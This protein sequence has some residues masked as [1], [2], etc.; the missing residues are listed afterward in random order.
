MQAVSSAARVGTSQ[1]NVMGGISSVEALGWV[2]QAAV[3]NRLA[4]LGRYSGRCHTR[5]ATGRSSSVGPPINESKE[6]ISVPVHEEQVRAEKRTVVYEEVGVDKRAVQETER[7]SDT[8]RREELVVD[9]EGRVE[10]D[11][12]RPSQSRPA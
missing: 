5:A 7:V 1:R 9:K 2:R 10:R 3:L 8:I 6:A 11:E 4:F 12:A